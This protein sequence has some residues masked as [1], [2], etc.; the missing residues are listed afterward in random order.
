MK[1]Y[2][3]AATHSCVLSCFS[4]CTFLN[5]DGPVARENID[6]KLS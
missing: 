5:V 4:S 3:M 2:V 6:K 1:K